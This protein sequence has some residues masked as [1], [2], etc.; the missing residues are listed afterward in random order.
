MMKRIIRLTE[1]DLVRLVKKVIN[2]KQ[3]ITSSW[4]SKYTDWATNKSG[5]PELAMQ[6][7]S[8]Y[9]DLKNHPEMPVKYKDFN[10]LKDANELQD[11]IDE[12]EEAV[13]IN[14]L[15]Q[16]ITRS[17]VFRNSYDRAHAGYYKKHNISVDSEARQMRKQKEEE[18][19]RQERESF[20]NFVDYFTKD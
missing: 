12:M 5:N 6:L 18:E 7:M 17:N 16:D 20:D 13:R 14:K 1:S 8:R 4:E 11:L 10:N 15:N 3:G 2:E 19:K 9:W